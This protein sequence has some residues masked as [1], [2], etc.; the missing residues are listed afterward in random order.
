MRYREIDIDE[1]ADPS[2]YTACVADAEIERDCTCFDDYMCNAHYAMMGSG[3]L[4][5]RLDEIVRV[6]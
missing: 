5:V 4:R 2:E 6:R 1:D 3:P